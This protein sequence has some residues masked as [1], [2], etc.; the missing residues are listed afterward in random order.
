MRYGRNRQNKFY[1]LAGEKEYNLVVLNCI[2]YLTKKNKNGY[3]PP[4]K[5]GKFITHVEEK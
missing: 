4:T 1:F 5:V 3:V 2:S